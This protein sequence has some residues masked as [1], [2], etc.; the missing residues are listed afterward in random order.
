MYTEF[1]ALVPVERTTS[2]FELMVIAQALYVAEDHCG[3]FLEITEKIALNSG[4]YPSGIAVDE[5]VSAP[6][7]VPKVF[8]DTRAVHTLPYLYTINADEATSMRVEFRLLL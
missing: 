1:D 4:L 7:N 8:N 5:I 2:P 3:K 6:V